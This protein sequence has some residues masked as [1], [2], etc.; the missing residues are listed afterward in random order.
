MLTMLW[1]LSAAI[2]GY[3]RAYMPSNRAV[4]WLRSQRGLKWAIPVALAATPAYLGALALCVQF[5]S[6]PGLG[7][8]NVLI[9]LFFWNAMKFTWMAVLSPLLMIRNRISRTHQTSVD[10]RAYESSSFT[11]SV[12][13]AISA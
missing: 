5:A 12:R 7:W 9:F 3:L 4:D 8:L 10:A 6:R 11:R 1:N 13:A 2:R